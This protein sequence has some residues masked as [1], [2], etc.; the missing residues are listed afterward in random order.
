MAKFKEMPEQT[1]D[2]I[3]MDMRMPFDGIGEPPRYAQRQGGREDHPDNRV[4]R[5]GFAED[6]SRRGSLAHEYTTKPMTATACS[7]P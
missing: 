4:L 2:C 7:R 1:F 6:I 3:L 5:N